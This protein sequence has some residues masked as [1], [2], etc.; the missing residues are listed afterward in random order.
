MSPNKGPCIVFVEALAEKHSV[1][2]SRLQ[3]I[4][5]AKA[6]A[7][8]HRLKRNRDIT[9][10]AY[11]LTRKYSLR[12]QSLHDKKQLTYKKYQKCADIDSDLL[13]CSKSYESRLQS[14]DKLYDIDS[15]TDLSY[16]QP[17]SLDLVAMPLNTYY[18]Q[19]NNSGGGGGGG[20]GNN[21]NANSNQNQKNQSSTQQQKNGR[22]A[23]Q[24]SAQT[25][26]SVQLLKRDADEEK[27]FPSNEHQQAGTP[28]LQQSH[29]MEHHVDM[30]VPPPSMPVHYANN[31]GY[32]QYYYPGAECVDPNYYNVPAEMVTSQPMYQVPPQAY[33]TT[34]IPMPAVNPYAVAPALSANQ[35]YSMPMA[36]WPNASGVT[37]TSKST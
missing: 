13:D 12:H 29:G 28:S 15:Y 33:A 20:G 35:M 3:P 21:H 27:E 25:E 8:P 11:D 4:D 18:R 16:F 7:L 14:I 10:N 26:S 24:T 9:A 23:Q 6:W 32:V 37:P 1:A 34:P 22:N 30:C 19:N 17:Y 31:G 2:Y 5:D 36:G